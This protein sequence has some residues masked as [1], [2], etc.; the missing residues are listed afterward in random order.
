MGYKSPSPLE[1]ESE[2]CLPLQFLIKKANVV[3]NKNQIVV[4][5]NL[6]I[7]ADLPVEFTIVENIKY[8]RDEEQS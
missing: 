3:L 1:P 7:V 5:I 8:H 6:R 2:D 4:D